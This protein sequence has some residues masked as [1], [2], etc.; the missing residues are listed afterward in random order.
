M[1]GT[2]RN[3]LLHSSAPS[4]FLRVLIVTPQQIKGGCGTEASRAAWCCFC[5]RQKKDTHHPATTDCVPSRN[6]F[7]EPDEPDDALR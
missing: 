6:E 7:A 1:S 5:C 4:L 2:Q 3:S